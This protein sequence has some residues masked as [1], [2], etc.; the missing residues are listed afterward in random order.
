MYG[1]ISDDEG[2]FMCAVLNV[3]QRSL[4]E[5]AMIATYLKITFGD[6]LL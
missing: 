1:S 6:A 5:S 4:A 2:V 3:E